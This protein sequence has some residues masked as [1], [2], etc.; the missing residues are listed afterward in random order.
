MNTQWAAF[1]DEFI[2]ISR[3]PLKVPTL[4]PAPMKAIN[5]P[6]HIGYKPASS[7][8]TFVG[9]GPAIV[10]SVGAGNTGT[11]VRPT[12]SA[13][14]KK[15]K[16]VKNVEK[17]PAQQAAP[18]SPP[19]QQSRGAFKNMA[20]GAGATALGAVGFEAGRGVGHRA[21]APMNSQR[22]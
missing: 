6:G 12:S 14:A 9:R 4:I 21:M 16:K 11:Y 18:S 1:V 2:K 13:P 7:A 19:L 10:P 15:V 8:A 20:V 17:A 3:V 5:H 22:G